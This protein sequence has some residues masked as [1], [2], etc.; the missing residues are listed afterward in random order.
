MRRKITHYLICTKIAKFIANGSSA[1]V[2]V[3]STL[4]APKVNDFFEFHSDIPSLEQKTAF[5]NSLEKDRFSLHKAPF[6]ISISFFS[7]IKIK[8]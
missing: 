5:H 2:E 3:R 7:K 4:R 6:Q 8:G 1:V